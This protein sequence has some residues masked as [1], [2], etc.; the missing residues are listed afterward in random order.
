MGK[1][2]MFRMAVPMCFACVVAVM[3]QD[4]MTALTWGVRQEVV[5]EQVMDTTLRIQMQEQRLAVPRTIQEP[6]DQDLQVERVVQA[7]VA[8]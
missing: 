8:V 4:T 6:M 2:P 3:E 5:E 7:L 1:I